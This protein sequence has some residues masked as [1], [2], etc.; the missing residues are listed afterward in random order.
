MAGK[1]INK[2]LLAGFVVFGVFLSINSAYA[3]ID[4][5]YTT[6]N[7]GDS[8]QKSTFAW[9]ETPWLYIKLS[10]SIKHFT[11]TWW[12]DPSGNSYDANLPTSNAS[13]QWLSLPDWNSVKTTGKWEING[14]AFYPKGA[15]DSATTNFTVTPEPISSA[16]FLLGG[17]TFVLGAYR[18]RKQKA[19]NI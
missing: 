9:D 19:I 18:K 12:N 7:T 5:F 8:V 17:A 13:T 16:L 1:S 2:L 14:N 15:S 4:S 10:N 3:A 6:G 11:S